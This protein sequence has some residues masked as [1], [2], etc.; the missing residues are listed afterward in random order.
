MARARRLLTKKLKAHLKID[1]LPVGLSLQLWLVL[2]VPG[3]V[4]VVAVAKQRTAKTGSRDQE[5]GFLFC[6]FKRNSTPKNEN[7]DLPSAELAVLLALE[8]LPMVVELDL[9]VVAVF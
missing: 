2:V 1:F 8:Y 7:F 6:F 9:V 5:S 3:L 4:L